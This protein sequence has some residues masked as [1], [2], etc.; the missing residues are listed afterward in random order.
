MNLAATPAK[1]APGVINRV[2]LSVRAGKRRL[3]AW[4]LKRDPK[5]LISTAESVVESLLSYR[6][7]EEPTQCAFEISRALKNNQRLQVRMGI[8]SGPV[9][10]WWM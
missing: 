10:V 3:N 4:S 7:L 9:V 2:L 6:S 1:A 5:F 8:H